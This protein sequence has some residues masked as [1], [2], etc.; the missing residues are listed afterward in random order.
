MF[1]AHVIFF[2]SL[3]NPFRK[4]SREQ[5]FIVKLA[6]G[7]WFEPCLLAVDAYWG[8]GFLKSI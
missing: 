7:S 4:I 2:S 6:S 5:S 1:E 3:S 8:G